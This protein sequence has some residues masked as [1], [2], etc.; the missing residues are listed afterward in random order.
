MFGV[1]LISTGT[2]EYSTAQPA[3]VLSTSGSDPTAEPMPR[4]HMPCGQPK[5]SSS[6]SQPVSIEAL[7]MSR[8]SS[9]DSTISETM[10][11]CLGYLRLT[12][13]ISRRLTSSGRSVMSSMLLKPTIRVPFTSSEP[14]RLE[15]ST[16]GSPSVFQ[17]APPQPASKARITWSPELAGG[18]LASQKG[19]GLW[20]PAKSIERSVMGSVGPGGRSP[21]R[22]TPTPRF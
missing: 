19:F 22:R 13:R 21:P 20:M 14:K 12:S 17:T 5:L 18:A 10:T 7:M 8:Q 16:I 3:T 2:V 1:S 15:V 4:S 11:A 9:L 6:P